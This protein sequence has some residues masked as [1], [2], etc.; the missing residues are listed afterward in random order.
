M[1][2]NGTG[3][4][5]CN[6]KGRVPWPTLDGEDSAE[7]RGEKPCDACGGFSQFT[8][9]S[10]AQVDFAP[11]D[12]DTI[13]ARANAA[14]EGPWES[15]LGPYVIPHVRCPT[16]DV[17]FTFYGEDD[18]ENRNADADAAFIAA[19][20]T[21]VPDL[22]AH[23]RALRAAVRRVDASQRAFDAAVD[24]HA[25]AKADAECDAAMLALFALVPEV[26]P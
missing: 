24:S 22:V 7:W 12:I 3:C 1:S 17:A 25:R 21:D 2:F 13:E 11:L 4:V 19:T 14:S 10:T 15:K 20:R 6:F 5:H 18:G 9:Q 8:R 23:V 26:T 16:H